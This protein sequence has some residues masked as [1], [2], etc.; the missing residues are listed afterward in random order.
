MPPLPRIPFTARTR[1]ALPNQ[2]ASDAL[3]ATK[4]A[5]K[6]I[7]ASSDACAPLKSGVSAALV[8]L[9]MS[10]KMKRNKADSKTLAE[11]A[12]Q[13]VLDIWGQTK[14]LNGRLP[15]EVERCI[16]EIETLFREIE[17]LF[18]ELEKQR[19]LRRLVRQDRHKAQIEEYG[20]LLDLATSQ[21]SINLQLSIHTAQLGIRSAQIAQ[22]AAD[23]KRHGAVLTVS[24][25]SEAERLLLTS[26]DAKIHRAIISRGVFFFFYRPRDLQ[27]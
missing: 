3:D 1:R 22:I 11:R 23:E 19:F 27:L 25:M 17:T 5:L 9:E 2:I 6:A 16:L 21:F 13:L 15:D 10:E 12:A 18:H 24:Q 7:R 26:L 20:R 14:D 8:L 4:V